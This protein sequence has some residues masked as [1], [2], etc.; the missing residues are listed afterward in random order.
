[1]D[2]LNLSINGKTVTAVRFPAYV[3]REVMRIQEQEFE[4]GKLNLEIEKQ[5][6][7]LKDLAKDS[8]DKT[9]YYGLYSNI[10]AVGDKLFALRNGI[11]DRKLWVISEIFGV[12]A[13]D[14]ERNLS[15]AEI[16]TQIKSI[17]M[18]CNGVFPKNA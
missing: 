8:E 10:N 15:V 9:A 1:M 2:V 12:T 17:V 3:A 16:E 13:D 14:I 7:A 4:I 6:D 18:A 11:S 5:K